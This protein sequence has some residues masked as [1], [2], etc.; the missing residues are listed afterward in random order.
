MAAP[1]ALVVTQRPG[2]GGAQRQ[3]VELCNHMDEARCE[4]H[5]CSPGG[6]CA[7]GG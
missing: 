5:V 4:M 1:A 2:I 7:V 3:V 6:L